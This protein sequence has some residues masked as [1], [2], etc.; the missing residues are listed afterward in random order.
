[1]YYRLQKKR[2][3][4]S[5]ARS[6][7]LHG[8]LHGEGGE[9][10]EQSRWMWWVSGEGTIGRGLCRGEGEKSRMEK[11]DFQNGDHLLLYLSLRKLYF[12]KVGVQSPTLGNGG[13][14]N[15]TLESYCS[16]WALI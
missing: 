8:R 11:E 2:P 14:G 7:F 15:G 6:F 5:V 16:V 9:G 4:S 1:M 12:Y 3:T 10:E 13:Q